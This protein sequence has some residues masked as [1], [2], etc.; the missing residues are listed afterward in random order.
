VHAMENPSDQENL[1][2]KAKPQRKAMSMKGPLAEVRAHGLWAEPPEAEVE[3]GQRQSD[4]IYQRQNREGPH[5]MWAERSSTRGASYPA[6]P[7]CAKAASSSSSSRAAPPKMSLTAAVKAAF[8]VETAED[9]AYVFCTYDEA[10]KAGLDA[11]LLR[12]GALWDACRQAASPDANRR[13][14]AVLEKHRAMAAPTPKSHSPLAVAI[15]PRVAARKHGKIGITSSTMGSDK[16]KREAAAQKA[17]DLVACCEHSMLHRN[18]ALHSAVPADCDGLREDLLSKLSCF[19][20]ASISAHIGM[21]SKWRYWLR[22][23][24]LVPHLAD[25]G[26]LV[27]FLRIQ[28][29][30]RC[31]KAAAH[32][33]PGESLSRKGFTAA[34][35]AWNHLEWW[36]CHGGCPVPS[37]GASSKPRQPLNAEASV[38]Q[39]PVLPPTVTL[40]VATHADTLWGGSNERVRQGLLISHLMLYGYLRFKHVQRSVLTA[41]SEHTLFGRCLR[42]KS[43]SARASFEWAVPRKGE[44][45]FDIGHHLVNQWSKESE[46]AGKPL[47]FLIMDSGGRCV[48]NS[49]ANEAL[50]DLVDCTDVVTNPELTTSYSFRRFAV[51]AAMMRRLDHEALLRLGSWHEKV[52]TSTDRTPAGMPARYTGEK[53]VD[54]A[55]EK[56]GQMLAMQEAFQNSDTTWEGMRLQLVK[57]LSTEVWRDCV[58]MSSAANVWEMPQ[59]W[60]SNDLKTGFKLKEAARDRL[61]RS[62]KPV[63][64]LAKLE[65]PPAPKASSSRP[66]A[67]QGK[68]Y[69]ITWLASAKG[70]IH[71]GWRANVEDKELLTECSFKTIA[72]SFN[73]IGLLTAAETCRDFCDTCYKKL[74]YRDQSFWNNRIVQDVRRMVRQRQEVSA[75]VKEHSQGM[76]RPRSPSQPPRGHPRSRS[77]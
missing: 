14:H 1:V 53:L 58:R 73:G 19:E 8:Q 61:K 26:H 43:N 16:A 57:P 25:A 50:K 44:C 68:G 77:E 31:D 3:W 27:L 47:P 21:W 12:I 54:Q 65:P 74:S 5:K 60:R 49:G 64:P 76:K 35:A 7:P 67:P 13:A 37:D 2:A 10:D 41:M 40:S 33:C 32:G 30:T 48:S 15:Q 62:A 46:R 39:A 36:R 71:L 18:L 28:K 4:L 55:I 11:G 70:K 42:G 59:E 75:R 22:E 63:L 45:G 72:G 23:K 38:D 29:Q 6:P 17:V 52:G 34:L 9:F 20:A 56:H 24:G 66:P 69:R 51:T